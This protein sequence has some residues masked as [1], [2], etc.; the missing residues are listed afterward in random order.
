MSHF[1]QVEKREM[2]AFKKLYT[3]Y[4]KFDFMNDK[5]DEGNHY[6]NIWILFLT[7]FTLK[8]PTF[9]VKEIYDI[10]VKKVN[11]DGGIFKGYYLRKIL[12]GYMNYVFHRV[13][14][15][16]NILYYT[17]FIQLE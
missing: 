3:L 7:E 13:I 9:S 6:N 10:I 12:L 2:N 14:K 5:A 11:N 16:Y 8:Y 4:S 15:L 17:F 1:M